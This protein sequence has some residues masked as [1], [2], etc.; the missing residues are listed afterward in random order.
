MSKMQDE[1]DKKTPMW[2]QLWHLKYFAPVKSKTNRNEK[3]IY[4]TLASVLGLNTVGN[5]YHIEIIEAIKQFFG[6]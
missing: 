6:G 1:L 4:I 2:F 5:Y 3:F